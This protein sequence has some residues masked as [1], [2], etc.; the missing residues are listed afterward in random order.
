MGVKKVYNTLGVY[1]GCTT[2]YAIR[3]PAN[4]KI[5][6][7]VVRMGGVCITGVLRKTTFEVIN[8]M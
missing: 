1:C 5:L 2:R 3:K 7:M 6:N 8:I 4:C